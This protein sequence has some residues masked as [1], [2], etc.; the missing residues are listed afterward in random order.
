MW[1]R[2][3]QP[4]TRGTSIESNTHNWAAMLL[5][6]STQHLMGIRRAQSWHSTYL[7][8]NKKNSSYKHKSWW[9]LWKIWS[10]MKLITGLREEGPHEEVR[11]HLGYEE[12]TLVPSKNSVLKTLKK[13]CIDR[14]HEILSC[15]KDENIWVHSLHQE[16]G[17]YGKLEMH[18]WVYIKRLGS[19]LNLTIKWEVQTQNMNLLLWWEACDPVMY[20]EGIRGFFNSRRKWEVLHQ[21]C[22][23]SWNCKK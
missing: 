3:Q 9:A 20:M 12:R 13:E 19:T 10:N 2:R 1:R 11:F 6:L 17:E 4:L 8:N 21:V 15:H 22:S 14:H 7:L 16:L 23:L 5:Y 18:G